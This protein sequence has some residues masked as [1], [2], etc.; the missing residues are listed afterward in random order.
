MLIF[1]SC[2]NLYQTLRISICSVRKR[3]KEIDEQNYQE[4][5]AADSDCN[6]ADGVLNVTNAG[7]RKRGNH[8][9]T[10]NR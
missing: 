10:T 9:T 4:I 8:Q 3:E 5:N 2:A 6:N 7:S 1:T